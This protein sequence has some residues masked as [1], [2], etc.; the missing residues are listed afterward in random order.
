M[1]G[2]MYSMYGE[3]FKFRAYTT[4]FVAVKKSTMNALNYAKQGQY[5]DP[6]AKN[7][8]KFSLKQCTES[9]MKCSKKCKIREIYRPICK[10]LRK[11]LI[12]QVCLHRI[13][14]GIN[15]RLIL[16]LFPMCNKFKKI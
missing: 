14:Q 9:N 10:K 11:I 5:I 1:Y 8:T 6:F 7:C 4:E 16:K 12:Q 3:N 13:I 15:P 2:P